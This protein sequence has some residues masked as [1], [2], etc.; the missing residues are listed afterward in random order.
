MLIED[1][2]LFESGGNVYPKLIW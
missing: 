2:S 1:F